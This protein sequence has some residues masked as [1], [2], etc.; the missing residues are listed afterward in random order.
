MRSFGDTYRQVK[1]EKWMKNAG[2]TN[3]EKKTIGRHRWVLLGQNQ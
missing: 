1:L 2:L 3:F